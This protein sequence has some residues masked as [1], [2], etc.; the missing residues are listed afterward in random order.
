MPEYEYRP[1]ME[2]ITQIHRL[3]LAG[4]TPNCRQLQERF[5]ASRSTVV[6]DIRFM[7]DRLKLPIV[8]TGRYG[9]YRYEG[10]V[11]ELPGMQ[12][13][14]G[15]I[16]ALCAAQQSLVSHLG[17]PLEPS[18]RAVVGQMKAALDEKLHFAWAEMESI[19]SFRPAAV[20]PLLD[21]KLFPLMVR[22]IRQQR[23][24][25][26]EYRKLGSGGLGAIRLLR[27]HHLLYA[28]GAWYLMANTPDR[29]AIHTYA[30]SR[31]KKPRLM[32]QTFTRLANFDPEALLADCIGLF[33]GSDPQTVRLRVSA[34]ASDWIMER[35][36]HPSQQWTRVKNGEVEMQMQVCLTPELE[37]WVM[38]W[39]PNVE[40][41]GPPELR[42]RIGE[43]VREMG[44][45]YG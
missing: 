36:W 7:K 28:T 8:S 45:I 26:L 23:E 43:L 41:L 18:M 14:E 2:R 10:E 27:P 31:M 44:T 38:Q 37:N 19:L 6:R 30:L 32:K 5:E 35:I 9:G 11:A 39:G 40:V 22:A 21:A 24:V 15:Q 17:T 42:Q 3:I 1:S 4:E 12:V 20:A 16:L 29:K 33:G 25:K 13:D 34:R